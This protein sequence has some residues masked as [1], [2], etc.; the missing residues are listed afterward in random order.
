MM[1][2]GPDYAWV[3]ALSLSNVGESLYPPWNSCVNDDPYGP[4]Y[5]IFESS[6]MFNF[7]V[8]SRLLTS[9]SKTKIT[10]E[11]IILLC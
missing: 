7:I 3:P 8:Q 6:Q 10:P 4:F 5:V 2:R 11:V 9:S 1:V